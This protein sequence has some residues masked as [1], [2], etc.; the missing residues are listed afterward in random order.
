MNFTEMT[1]MASEPLVGGV[2]TR[3]G[4]FCSERNL[5][6]LSPAGSSA[7]A[8]GSDLRQQL[9]QELGDGRILG[10]GAF[11]DGAAAL[12]LAQQQVPEEAADVS[13]AQR[14]VEDGAAHRLLQ[15][16]EEDQLL[17]DLRRPGG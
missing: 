6:T 13:G 8:S 11:W 17:I 16:A 2:S 1:F 14:V 7:G 9:L 5:Q 4:R 3:S 10:G 12:L 15:H